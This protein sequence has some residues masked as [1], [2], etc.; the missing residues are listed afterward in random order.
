MRVAQV[1][2]DPGDLAVEGVV[3]HQPGAFV[4][5]AQLLHGIDAVHRPLERKVDVQPIEQIGEHRDDVVALCLGQR[6]TVWRLGNSLSP[7]QAD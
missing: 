5:T 3:R 6:L 7:A 4:Q 1:H 2:E